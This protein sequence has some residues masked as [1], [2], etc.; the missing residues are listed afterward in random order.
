LPREKGRP[1]KLVIFDMGGVVDSHP[2]VV[3]QI[4]QS[5]RISEQKF[6]ELSGEG[7]LTA[8]L[9]GRI[10]TKEFWRQFSDRYGSIITEDLWATYFDPQLDQRMVELASTLKPLVRVVV[11]TNTLDPHYTAHMERGNYTVFDAVYA[12]N[13]I[14]LAKPDPAF[15]TY[16]LEAEHCTPGEAVFIDDSEENVLP[17]RALGLKA[18]HFTDPE[19]LKSRLRLF[20]PSL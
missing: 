11:G 1:P 7:N 15:Y 17:A 20:F 18:I 14:G 5:L 13:K 8:L 19:A 10:S 6:F 4:A 16:I 3:P 2:A 9:T 12:S